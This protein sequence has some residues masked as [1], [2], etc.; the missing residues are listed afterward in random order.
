MKRD[1]D[2][3]RNI[4]LRLEQLPV[5]GEGVL[6]RTDG[7]VFAGIDTDP[8][9]LGYHVKLLIDHGLI[10]SISKNHPS[11]GFV[12]QGLSWGGHD[13]VDSVRSEDVWQKTKAGAQRAGG[14]TVDLLLDFAKAVIRHELGEIHS[15]R[16]SVGTALF[17][18][19]NMHSDRRDSSFV[20][21]AGDG[22]L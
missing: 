12:F 16:L 4:L 13:F 5:K 7:E 6:V 1:M 9:A 3:I 20:D 15:R 8:S 19:N 22:F 18:R 11:M 10:V 17:P 14:W 2:L 21:H